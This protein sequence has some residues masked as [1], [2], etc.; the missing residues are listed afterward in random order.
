MKQDYCLAKEYCILRPKQLKST[1]VQ[2]Q[3]MKIIPPLQMHFSYFLSENQTEEILYCRIRAF[4]KEPI[5]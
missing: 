3:T 2:G 5:C 1:I 4:L